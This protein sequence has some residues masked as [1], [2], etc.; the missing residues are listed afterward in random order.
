MKTVAG[1]KARVAAWSRSS[2]MIAFYSVIAGIGIWQLAY[3]GLARTYYFEA[4]GIQHFLSSPLRVIQSF[5]ELY[6]SGELLRHSYFSLLEFVY[7][8]LVAIV[9]GVGV[10]LLA[11]AGVVTFEILKYAERRIASW[12][13]HKV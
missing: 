1:R 9:V 13:E 10:A 4:Y 2:R 8:F 3:G 12:C 7:G 6:G 11:I 5:A